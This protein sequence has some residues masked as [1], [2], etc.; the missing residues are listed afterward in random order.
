MN[1][2]ANEFEFSILGFYF[3]YSFSTHISD[4]KILLRRL[5]KARV[6][7]SSSLYHEDYI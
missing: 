2:S 1:R 6:V 4:I 3:I 5:V 7:S